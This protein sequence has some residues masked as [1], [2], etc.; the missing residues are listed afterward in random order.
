MRK[1]PARSSVSGY[2]RRRFLTQT[3][4]LGSVLLA[5]RAAL[6]QAATPRP[7]VAAI[8]TVLRFR[9]HAYNILENFLGPYY[10]NGQLTDPGVDIVAFYADQFPTDDMAREVSQRF[11]IPLFDSIDAALCLGR[12]RLAVDGVLS[13][14]EHG[15]YPFNERGQQLY[16]RKSFFDQSLAVMKRSDR[17]VPYFNDK[18]LSYRWDWAREMYDTARE[19]K[20]PLMAGSSVPL[21]Q[22]IPP[23]ELPPGSKIEEAVSI[24]GGGL[25]SYDFHGLEVLQ[26]IVE[27][28]R[29]GE[30]GISRVQ[31]F[32]GERFEQARAQGRWSQELVD[33]AMQSEEQMQATRQPRP[34]TGVFTAQPEPVAAARRP[35]PTGPHAIEVT[36]KDGLK[37]TVLTVGSTSDRWNFACRLHG[38]SEPHATAYFNSPWGNR[39]LFK[40][41]SHAIQHLFIHAQEPYPAERTLLTTGATEAVMQSYEADGEPIETPHL[42][43]AYQPKDWQAMR[44]LGQT[45]NIITADTPQPTEFAPRPFKELSP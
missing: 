15:D 37:A 23:L 14:A 12:E 33:R 8:F 13:I 6:G 31:L 5:S 26:S 2:S 7:K 27:S 4:G 9:S 29:G 22:R 21:A 25:E 28:R 16:P 24:H 44:E 18:H 38:E 17:F 35:R 45:W 36:Y 42:H 10:F 1:L 32:I 43:I 20:M 11:E 39:G 41:L 3:A 34:T 30:T 40:A 19:H